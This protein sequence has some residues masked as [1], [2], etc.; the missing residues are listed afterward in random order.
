M[1]TKAKDQTDILSE[2]SLAMSQS[3]NDIQASWDAVKKFRDTSPN[4]LN[5][6]ED[7]R[8]SSLMTGNVLWATIKGYGT[9]FA[10]GTLPP[11]IHRS[12]VIRGLQ[13]M[14]AEVAHLPEALANCSS[15]VSMY[16]K[17]TRASN[18]LALETFLLEV[19]R[20]YNEV[21]HFSSEKHIAL[22][23]DDYLGSE[24]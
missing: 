14:S 1:P 9:A 11:F 6:K 8:M 12:C 16:L 13:G 18:P 23:A 22:N 3:S 24:A 2:V 17:K 10:D 19:Q 5:R 7:S 4:L 21:S 20:I 15:I